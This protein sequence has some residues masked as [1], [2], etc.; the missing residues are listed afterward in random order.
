MISLFAAAA[1]LADQSLIREGLRHFFLA[2]A[3]GFLVTGLALA[4][5]ARRIAG[6]TR[7]RAGSGF[8]QWTYDICHRAQKTVANGELNRNFPTT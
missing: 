1:R 4:V 7:P 5:A 8:R 2:L 6:T 3:A